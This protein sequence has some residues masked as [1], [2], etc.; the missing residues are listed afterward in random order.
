MYIV[1]RPS[2][3]LWLSM[4]AQNATYKTI[5]IKIYIVWRLEAEQRSALDLLY[6]S[7]KSM[8][9]KQKGHSGVWKVYPQQGYGPLSYWSTAAIVNV[10]WGIEAIVT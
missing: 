8:A 2:T 9:G 10:I 5:N 6:W 4:G 1:R 3:L 7:Q